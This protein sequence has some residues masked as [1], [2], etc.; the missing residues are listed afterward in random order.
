MG[1]PK[2]K[3]GKKGG[4]K[5]KGKKTAEETV[6]EEPEV[7]EQESNEQADEEID[8]G[9]EEPVVADE[10]VSE[11]VEEPKIEERPQSSLGRATRLTRRQQALADAE[12]ETPEEPSVKADEDEAFDQATDETTTEEAPEPKAIAGEL[13]LSPPQPS[14]LDDTVAVP[15]PIVLEQSETSDAL[16]PTV[17]NLSDRTRTEPLSL[18]ASNTTSG[19]ASQVEDPI[20]AI[21]ALEDEIDKVV[22]IIPSLDSPLSPVKPRVT[23]K[24]DKPK[25]VLKAPSSSLSRPAPVTK[26]SANRMAATTQPSAT[27]RIK[28]LAEPKKPATAIA[29]AVSTKTR[30]KPI[31]A[32]SKPKD[33]H[34]AEKAQDGRPVDH[35]VAKRRPVSVSFPTPP[36][37]PKSKKPTTTASF[38]LPG[39][40]V[41]AKLKAQKLERQKREEE[42]A[43]KK[44]EF[45]ARPAPTVSTSPCIRCGYRK[46]LDDASNTRLQ[47]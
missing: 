21:D 12:V 17:Q 1:K 33:K 3:K 34:I 43:A 6:N 5:K 25:A 38:T 10:P 23:K 40:A 45:K 39:E 8:D 2:G 42:E 28:S 19:S 14:E 46:A 26:P 22:K 18:V 27:T 11:P 24:A 29:R 32:E 4:A 7:V 20:E 31:L 16:S 13:I 41:A 15:T 9:I 47:V 35:L 37:P 36:P 30:P 44:R